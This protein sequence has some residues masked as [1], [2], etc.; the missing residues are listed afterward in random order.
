[1]QT[2]KCIDCG[3]VADMCAGSSTACIYD[4]EAMEPSHDIFR[5]LSCTNE[6]GCAPS[7]ARPSN[8]DVSGYQE[9]FVEDI[10]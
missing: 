7:N 2:E 9:V 10:H 8:N 5:C 3:K 4:F 6:H 1:M